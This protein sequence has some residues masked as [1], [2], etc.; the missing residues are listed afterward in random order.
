MPAQDGAGADSVADE[1]AVDLA[2]KEAKQRHDVMS[3][4]MN[5]FARNM[6]KAVL[7]DSQGDMPEDERQTMLAQI[8]GNDPVVDDNPDATY[9]RQQAHRHRRHMLNGGREVP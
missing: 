1:F 5:N 4:F 3:Q 9:I 8:G 6:R 2:A 7:Q